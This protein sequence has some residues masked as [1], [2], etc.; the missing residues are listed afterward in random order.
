MKKLSKVAILSTIVLGG[1]QLG[2]LS[3]EAVELGWI[4]GEPDNTP[5]QTIQ[6]EEKAEVAVE[7]WVGEWDPVTPEDKDYI[8]ITI[9]TTVRYANGMAEDGTPQPEIVSP[10]Y[11]MTNNSNARNVKV[12]V[13]K[14]EETSST[15][16]T[17]D[18]Y[19]TALNEPAVRLQ[20]ASG[21]FL[22]TK[23]YLTT[24]GKQQSKAL[25]FE[26][27]ITSEFKENEIV[28]PSYK[29]SLHFTALKD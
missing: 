19:F 24:I 15:S 7:G 2:A 5:G 21:Q 26:G 3:T 28:T 12:E 13:E 9:P 4:P 14:F 8:D 11:S 22:N 25:K 17:Q 6:K 20:S 1:L 10:L 18:L 27:M 16:I 23:T 29:M